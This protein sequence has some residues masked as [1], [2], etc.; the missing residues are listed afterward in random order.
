MVSLTLVFRCQR[1]V[2]MNTQIV[3]CRKTMPY[4]CSGSMF[5]FQA[6]GVSSILT[7]GT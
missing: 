2:E 3:V 5:A 7:Y 1:S 6:K 4:R